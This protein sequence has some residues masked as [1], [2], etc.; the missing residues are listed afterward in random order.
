[1]V[2]V[3]SAGN[4]PDHSFGAVAATFEALGSDGHKHTG[5]V[6]KHSSQTRTRFVK[7][8]CFYLKHMRSLLHLLRS[9]SCRQS[10]R[11]QLSS[12]RWSELMSNEVTL[13]WAGSSCTQLTV[14]TDDTEQDVSIAST[15]THMD[16]GLLKN[17]TFYD[18]KTFVHPDNLHRWT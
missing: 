7:T 11:Q 4:S 2:S 17:I 9:T 6:N 15:E 12:W 10:S 3:Q 1:M 13:P 14:L 5:P 8:S 18:I 16:F